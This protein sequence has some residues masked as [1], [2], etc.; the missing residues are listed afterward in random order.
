[1]IAYSA[2]DDYG[3]VAL[4]LVIEDPDAPGETEETP[5]DLGGVRAREVEGDPLLDL[6][7]HRWAGRRVTMRLRAVDA[8]GQEG[9]SEPVE[10]RIPER[11]FLSPLARAVAEQ[12]KV[13][14]NAD[15]PYADLPELPP[16]T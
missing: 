6:T 1:K 15:A 11:I 16:M 10:A 13:L 2:S 7:E 5:I 4:G 8:V 9:F 14:M 12:R 3:V